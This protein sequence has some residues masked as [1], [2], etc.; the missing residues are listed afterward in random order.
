M[1]SLTPLLHEINACSICAAHLP[2]AP[3]PVLQAHGDAR[4]LIVGQAPGRRVHES[5]VP[6][7]DPSGV[8]LRAWMGVDDPTF[9]DATK[10]AIVPMGFCFPGSL[11]SGDLPPRPE[12]APAWR[13]RVLAELPNVALTLVL[14]RY[15]QHWHLGEPSRNVTESVAAWEEYW[16]ELLPLPHPSPRNQGWFKR[17]AWFEVEVLPLLRNRVAELLA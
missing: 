14:G 12:C 10:V 13:E 2:H 3:R 7:Q 15:A 11:K 1:S 5:G 6:F 4:V 9:Y 8:R 17:N 16:P